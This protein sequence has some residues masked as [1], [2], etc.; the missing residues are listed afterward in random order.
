LGNDLIIYKNLFCTQIMKKIFL[1]INCAL[2]INSATLFAANIKGKVLDNSAH[3]QL[4]GAT[5]SIKGTNIGAI[6]NL[7]G[8]YKINN[9]VDG[10]YTLVC[11]YVGFEIQEINITIAGN[12]DIQKDIYLVEKSNQLKEISIKVGDKES[13]N[14][15]RK[16]EQAAD[17]LMNVISAKTID[18]SPDLTVGNVLRRVSG[19]T[20][21]SN[22][23]GHAQYAI[24]RGMDKR[25]NY[26]LLN[27]I[28]VPSPDNKNRF[29]PMD[30]F[31]SDMLQKLEVIK[32][33]T[34]NMEGDAIGG[35]TNI[36]MILY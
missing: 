28:K 11:K 13:D 25:Y 9:I 8:T 16:A 19:V 5:V 26:T 15:A 24:I 18:L 31:P 36:V 2:L 23:S 35:V 30:L 1:L 12:V 20:I 6:T 21:Q 4:I 29:V 10:S 17:H 32:S 27:G 3:E 22:S 34:P 33:L 7:D 14:S